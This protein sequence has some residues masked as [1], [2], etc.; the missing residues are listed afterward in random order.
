MTPSDSTHWTVIHAAAA[1]DPAARDTFARRYLPAV[2]AYLGARW[3]GGPLIDRLEDA[4]Q[5]VF[6]EC[7]RE[8]GVL[9]RLDPKNGGGFRALLYGVTRNVARRH[10]ERFTRR[11]KRAPLSATALQDIVHSDPSPG[12]AFDRAWASAVMRE[13]AARQLT[14]ARASG[15][16]AVARVELLRQR[17]AEGRPIREIAH[18]RGED[19]TVVHRQ[20]ARARR[21]FLAA[22]RSVV[23]ELVPGSRE[24]VEDESRRLLEHFR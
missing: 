9:T 21:E 17:I 3:R 2:R 1:G 24:V 19:A 4:A 14:A 18:L 6:V 16:E 8:A 23:A 22:L 13:A 12:E 7:F 15:E 5:D 20:Y 11:A 10:E